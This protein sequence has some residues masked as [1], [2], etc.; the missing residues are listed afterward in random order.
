MM[1]K[2]ADKARVL[3]NPRAALRFAAESLQ[4]VPAKY[5]VEPSKRRG[6]DFKV[7]VKISECSSIEKARQPFGR[8]VV[9]FI[10][11]LARVS[12]RGFS[13]CVRRCRIG[14]DV[15]LRLPVRVRVLRQNIAAAG[16]VKA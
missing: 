6:C 3:G 16:S 14:A 12:A 9:Q 10:M 15:E 7:H 5:D 13:R 4:Y 8:N 2:K 1:P 11:L